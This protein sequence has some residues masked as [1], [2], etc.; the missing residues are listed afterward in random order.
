MVCYWDCVE[1]CDEY[2]Y[3]CEGGYFDEVGYVDWNVQQQ[4][5]VLVFL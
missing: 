2:G 1:V 3:Q 5:C 4:Q